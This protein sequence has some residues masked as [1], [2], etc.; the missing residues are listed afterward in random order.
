MD[1]SDV[2]ILS[3]LSTVDTLLLT[4]SEWILPQATV[5]TPD[6]WDPP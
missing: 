5:P 1:L 4:F 6:S 3:R 2:R